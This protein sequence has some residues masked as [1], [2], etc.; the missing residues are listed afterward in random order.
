M[1]LVLAYRNRALT[2][3]IVINDASG[4][5]ITPGVSDL[6][7]VVIGWEGYEADSTKRVFTVTSGTPT[8]NGSTLVAGATNVLNIVSADLQFAAGTYMF[9]VDFF[10]NAD[11]QWKN[12]DREVFQLEDT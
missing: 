3:N 12:V 2:R 9:F 6:V 5:P 1:S 11:G 8:V 4:N 10:D 7:R